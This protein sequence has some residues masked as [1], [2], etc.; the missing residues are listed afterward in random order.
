MEH[1]KN[2]EGSKK[3][4]VIGLDGGTFDLVG[5]WVREG[6]L[7]NFKRLLE[8]GLS[9]DLSVELPPGTVPN[10][11]SFMTGKNAGKHG[12]IHWFTRVKDFSKWTIVNSHSIKEKTLWE[13][14]A[15]HK[16]K[17]FLPSWMESLDIRFRT[18]QYLMSGYDWDLF[19]IVFSETDA[20]QHAFWKFTDPT[21]PFYDKELA[22]RYGKGILQVYQQVDH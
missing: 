19:M 2:K 11:P 1:K 7:P 17:K 18:S 10:W 9:R 6:H 8:E 12:V 14:V 22:K 15:S 13:I 4:F 16:K 20:V 21:H 5:P 3:V